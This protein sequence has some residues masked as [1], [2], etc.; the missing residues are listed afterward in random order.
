MRLWP[1]IEASNDSQIQLGETVNY[2]PASRAQSMARG[3][4]SATGLLPEHNGQPEYRIK[5]F[6]EDYERI[7]Q[8][9]ELSAV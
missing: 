3:I 9:A 1:I 8:E 2:S 4:Y 6:A 5:H 7:A